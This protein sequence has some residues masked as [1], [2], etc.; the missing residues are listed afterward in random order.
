M[1]A[2]QN[3][4]R[5]RMKT[6]KYTPAND[7]LL[8]PDHHAIKRHAGAFGRGLRWEAAVARLERRNPVNME[9]L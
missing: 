7:P 2:K 8:N 4:K 1:K 6:P 3:N 5:K 9:S